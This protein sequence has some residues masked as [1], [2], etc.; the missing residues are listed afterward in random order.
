MGIQEPRKPLS[1]V[2]LHKQSKIAP[3][4]LTDSEKLARI[5]LYRSENV[6]PITFYQLLDRYKTAVEALEM[7]P[8][9]ARRGGHTSSLHICPLAKVQKELELHQKNDAQL[10]VWGELSYPKQ[11]ISILDASPVLSFKGNP[12]FLEQKNHC[13]CWST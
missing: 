9:L 6:G 7:L 8:E 5:Q 1:L 13:H 12:M 3:T 11:L 10:V 2:H 4:T